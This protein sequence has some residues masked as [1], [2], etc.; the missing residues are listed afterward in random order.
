MAVSL[1]ADAAVLRRS[2][3]HTGRARRLVALLLV[4]PLLLY[5]AV[6]FIVPLGAILARAVYDPDMANLAP[7]TLA[8]LSGWDG[9]AVPD[10]AMFAAMAADLKSAQAN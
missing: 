3:R 8:A 7:R 1:T 6:L 5:V 10:E 9:Q 4:T 2:V